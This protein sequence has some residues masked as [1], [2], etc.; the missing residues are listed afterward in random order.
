[1]PQNNINDLQRFL[2]NHKAND[3][4]NIT[5]TRIGDKKLGIFGGSYCIDEQE[6]TKFL[7]VYS[8]TVFKDNINEYL[9]EKQIENGPILVDF[10]FRYNM[11]VSTRQHDEETIITIMDLYTEKLKKILNFDN[12]KEFPIYIFEKPSINIMEKE[13]IVKDGIHMII[14]ISMPNKVQ[15][16]LRDEVLKDIDSLDLDLPLENSWDSVLDRG[17]TEGYTNWQ[18]YGSRK[19]NNEAY[20][21]TKYYM[22]RIDLNDMEFIINEMET[23]SLDLQYDLFKL[24]AQ[25]NKHP[26]FELSESFK[27]KLNPNKK[28]KTKLKLKS[29]NTNYDINDIKSMDELDSALEHIINNNDSYSFNRLSFSIKEIHG[30]VMLL[31]ES[32]Y[33]KGSYDKWIRVGIALYHT[34][35]RLFLSWIKFSSQS[36]DFDFSD[37]P[38]FFEL[39]KK[40]GENKK[41]EL[42]HRSIMFWARNDAPRDKYKEFRR[43]T[44][45]YYIDIT[46]AGDFMQGCEN[47][48]GKEMAIAAQCARD[49]DLAVVLYQMFKDQFICYSQSGRG[50]SI[51]NYPV[52]II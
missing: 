49:Y 17:I 30:Y 48:K 44:L 40:F 27:D 25:Y 11:S 39:W 31:P 12:D 43:E 15:C 41:E 10:D 52:I 16:L 4:E 1:M 18:M 14:G 50:K 29:I 38:G 3:K 8:K 28:K 37:I 13:Q 21:L 46:V 35:R 19:P 33:G 23:S 45:D 36:K 51:T 32:Y 20:Q 24:S 47:K 2:R 6:L 22:A 26:V 9:T 5:H 7:N 42:T 34:D